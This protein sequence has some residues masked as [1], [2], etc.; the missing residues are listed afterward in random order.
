MPDESYGMQI[1]DLS[2]DSLARCLKKAVED[3]S[4]RT[5]AAEK[6]F[7]NLEQNFVGEKTCDRLEQIA[8]KNK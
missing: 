4:W 1:K 6:A 2:A 8:L 7:R 3:E 5:A